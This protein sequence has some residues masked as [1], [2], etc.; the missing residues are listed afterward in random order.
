MIKVIKHL[1]DGR[2]V[3]LEEDGKTYLVSQ[4]IPM[5]TPVETLV[6]PC[7][8]EGKVTDWV[9]VAGEVGIGIDKYLQRVLEEG[10]LIA[11]W[12]EDDLPF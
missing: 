1:E 6:F 10:K 3:I 8:E 4:S 2:Q 11:P 5:H 7:D 9:E 12:K